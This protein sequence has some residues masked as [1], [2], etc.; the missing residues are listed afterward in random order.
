MSEFKLF[1]GDE[2]SKKSKEL[3]GK[4]LKIINGYTISQMTESF[5]YVNSVIKS[6]LVVDTSN[7]LP[8]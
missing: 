1:I 7:R 2:D 8:E 3:S 5:R 4:I 6:S